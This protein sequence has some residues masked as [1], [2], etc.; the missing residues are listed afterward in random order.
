MGEGGGEGS[1]GGAEQVVGYPRPE[2]SWRGASG[3]DFG[4]LGRCRPGHLPSRP[5]YSGY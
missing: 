2:L 4:L 3:E 5:T 1:S